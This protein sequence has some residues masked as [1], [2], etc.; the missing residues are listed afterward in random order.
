MKRSENGEKEEKESELPKVEVFSPSEGKPS[1]GDLVAS[2]SRLEYRSPTYSE[3]PPRR[4]GGSRGESSID[5]KDRK[6]R[7]RFRGGRPDMHPC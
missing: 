7:S 6:G 5:S 4:V 2:E 1:T 3:A